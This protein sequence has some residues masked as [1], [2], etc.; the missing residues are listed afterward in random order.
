MNECEFDFM[1][2]KF[3]TGVIYVVKYPDEYT[4]K[5]ESGSAS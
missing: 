4:S 1:A 2:L 3:L 5:N